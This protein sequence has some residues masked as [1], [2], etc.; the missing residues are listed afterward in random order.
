MVKKMVQFYQLALKLIF[1]NHMGDSSC[2]VPKKLVNAVKNLY[3]C[4]G[5][6]SW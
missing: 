2:R 5:N 3:F 6:S 1:Y 4:M